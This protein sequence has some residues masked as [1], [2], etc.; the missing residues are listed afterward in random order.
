L[1]FDFLFGCR[2]IILIGQDESSYESN[3]KKS[4]TWVDKDRKGAMGPKGRGYGFMVSQFIAREWGISLEITEEILELA[5]AKRE[6]E[7]YTVP[8]CVEFLG[9][10]KSKKENPLVEDHVTE[11]FRFGKNNFWTCKRIALQLEDLYDL[12]DVH[13]EYSVFYRAVFLNGL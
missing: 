3:L 8:S 11:F 4:D 5:N 13:P 2:P 7:E 6:D 9:I 1:Q 12:L 10:S